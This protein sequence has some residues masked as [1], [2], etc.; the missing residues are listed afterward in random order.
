MQAAE[1]APIVTPPAPL[2]TGQPPAS[3]PAAP[4]VTLRYIETCKRG[5][6][7][8]YLHDPKTGARWATPYRCRSW[9]HEGECRVWRARENLARMLRPLERCE[10]RHVLLLVLTFDQRRLAAGLA[11]EHMAGALRRAAALHSPPLALEDDPRWFAFST[12]WRRWQSL[13]QALNREA[14]RRGARRA[15]WVQTVEVHKSGWPHANVMLEWPWLAEELAQVDAAHAGECPRAGLPC[16][17]HQARSSPAHRCIPCRRK[18]DKAGERCGHPGCVRDWLASHAEACGFGRVVYLQHARDPKDLADYCIKLAG[19]LE[20]PA[21]DRQ[22]AG[23]PPLHPAVAEVVK[24]SQVP[25]NAPAHFR[26]L[27]S[28]RSSPSAGVEAMLDPPSR[29]ALE[30]A[31]CG[32]PASIVAA[33]IAADLDLVEE[34]DL[35]TGE[36]TRLPFTSRGPPATVAL[37]PSWPPSGWGVLLDRWRRRLPAR[38]ERERREAAWATWAAAVCPTP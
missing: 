7:A 14:G 8:L 6:W 19:E 26:R 27:R 13:R 22:A 33:A 20:A 34:V 17:R 11:M 36:V 2:A 31:L 18:R 1:T 16:P 3:S 28:S 38:L 9:R 12:L 5:G 29:S 15:R 35:A 4:G 23:L 25:T 32:Q 24:F 10:P 21:R 30:G 37:P